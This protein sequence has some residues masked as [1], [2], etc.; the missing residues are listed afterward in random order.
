MKRYVLLGAAI[1]V[2]GVAV[3]FAVFR[4]GAGTAEVAQSKPV[5]LVRVDTVR[6]G[7]ISEL[8]EITGSIEATRVARLAAPV[9]G[10]VVQLAKREG[11]RVRPG[12]LIVRIGRNRAA[13]ALLASAQEDLT[14]QEQEVARIEQL[15]QRGAIASEQLD[16]A[17]AQ[18]ERARAAHV[19]AREGMDDFVLSAPW[20]GVVS[21]V[22]VAEGNFAAPRT[23]LVEVYDPASL[24][25]KCAIPEARSS[26]VK[27][28]MKIAVQ[29]DAYPGR[30]LHASV[31]RVYGELDRR[32]RTLAV[33][34]RPDER[35]PLLPGMFAR[36]NVPLKTVPDAIVVP[37]DAI[38]ITAT[39]Q[40][41]VFVMKDGKVARKIVKTG[42]EARGRVQIIHG[43]APGD[44]VVVAGNESLK[45][46]AK[47]RVQG[48]GKAK[49]A[50]SSGS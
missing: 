49:K 21:R 34:A 48:A 24:V 16:W 10:P 40:R 27:P 19:R 18:L 14:R 31:S 7:S 28:G 26:V 6:T 36:L 11:D 38:V 25:I 8:L 29:L 15:V 44:V 43:V 45:D 3:W 22:E 30:Q 17:R 12:E 46:G 35:L 9:E 20:A 13:A 1:V 39:G 4:H 32:T 2:I 5:P 33:E 23:P 50:G 47:V 37:S 42:I 41:V